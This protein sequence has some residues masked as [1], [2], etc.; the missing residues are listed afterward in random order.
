MT[1]KWFKQNCFGRGAWGLLTCRLIFL[2]M[3]KLL[4]YASDTAD[5]CIIDLKNL[6]DSTLNYRYTCWYSCFQISKQV[7]DYWLSHFKSWDGLRCLYLLFCYLVTEGMDWLIAI[8]Y[9]QVATD[10]VSICS[11]VRYR[12]IYVSLDLNLSLPQG[13]E[14]LRTASNTTEWVGV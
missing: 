3:R 11:S 5:S 2:P 7:Q 6:W 13:E 8:E 1:W 9:P 10:G 12:P 14:I 4:F